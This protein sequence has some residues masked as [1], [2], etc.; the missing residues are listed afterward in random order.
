MSDYKD[1]LTLSVTEKHVV[2]K[3]S[4]WTPG[5]LPWAKPPIWSHITE[6]ILNSQSLKHGIKANLVWFSAS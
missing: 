6:V 2:M 4:V 5:L 3:W 1:Q